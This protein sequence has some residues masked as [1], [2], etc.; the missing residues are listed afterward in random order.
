MSAVGAVVRAGRQWLCARAGRTVLYTH[1][2][3]NNRR[4]RRSNVRGDGEGIAHCVFPQLLP[5]EWLRDPLGHP[6]FKCN[7]SGT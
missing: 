3:A 5:A 2:A 4:L 1:T 6:H 7:S